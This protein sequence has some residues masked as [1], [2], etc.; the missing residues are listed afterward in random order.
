MRREP[1]GH[2]RSARTT[3]LPEAAVRPAEMV[4]R[5]PPGDLA[6][7]ASG[8]L[9]GGPGAAGECGDAHARGQVHAFDERGLSLPQPRPCWR[10][11]WCISFADTASVLHL[12]DFHMHS[13]QGRISSG[14]AFHSQDYTEVQVCGRGRHHGRHARNGQH[15]RH[16]RQPFHQ[17]GLALFR[18]RSILSP[19]DCRQGRPSTSGIRAITSTLPTMRWSR[20]SS[21]TWR[22]RKTALL[23]DMVFRVASTS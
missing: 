23:R 21:P 16:A 5:T 8:S 11:G 4:V 12:G 10:S 3:V 9:G 7:Q 22:P 19:A 13:M 6:L 2:R 20:A 15:L 17:T 18:R 14:A 1:G